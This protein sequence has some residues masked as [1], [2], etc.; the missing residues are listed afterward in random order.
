MAVGGRHKKAV[1]VV[2]GVDRL[3]VRRE[4][5]ND[6]GVAAVSRRPVPALLLVARIAE[7]ER[8]GWLGEVEKLGVSLAGAPQTSSRNSTPGPLRL[9]GLSSWECPHSPKSHRKPPAPTSHQ[10][11]SPQTRI[12]DKRGIEVPFPVADEHRAGPPTRGERPSS[13]PIDPMTDLHPLRVE[14]RHR[15]CAVEPHIDNGHR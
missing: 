9:S 12:G 6:N 3:R 2:L 13:A 4:R 14:I 11:A 5:G 8:E 1:R 7:A 15:F 10:P